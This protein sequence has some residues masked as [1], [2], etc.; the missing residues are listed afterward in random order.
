MILAQ[1]QIQAMAFILHELA[2]N[3]VKHGA[4]SRPEGR[5]RITWQ[6]EETQAGRQLSLDWQERGGPTVHPRAPEA[7]A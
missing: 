3:S 5:L 4:L 2:T 6:V 1:Q 7:S